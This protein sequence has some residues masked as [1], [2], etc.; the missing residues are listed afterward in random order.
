ME[1][2]LMEEISGVRSGSCFLEGAKPWDYTLLSHLQTVKQLSR[3]E[4][5][6]L[7]LFPSFHDFFAGNSCVVK[8]KKK[9]TMGGG[10]LHVIF[11]LQ[12]YLAVN[13]NHQLLD[14]NVL[15]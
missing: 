7:F 1:W 8:K 14:P 5:S 12:Q 9:G 4:G 13:N 10:K 6:K 3:A 11:V 15:S 2:V